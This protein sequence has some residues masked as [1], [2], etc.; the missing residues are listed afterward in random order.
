M[1]ER[2]RQPPRYPL[3]ADLAGV[4]EAAQRGRTDDSGR[5]F[6][7]LFSLG[8]AVRGRFRPARL[9]SEGSPP[10]DARTPPG[11]A[12]TGATQPLDSATIVR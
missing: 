1:I 11:P 7:W 9:L 6:A 2:G 3:T 10:A 5:G 8:R 12:V 4:L